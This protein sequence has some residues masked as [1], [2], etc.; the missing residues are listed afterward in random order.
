MFIMPQDL[1]LLILSLIAFS[2]MLIVGI[3]YCSAA[4]NPARRRA[5]DPFISRRDT[6]P[7]PEI[8][9]L[10]PTNRLTAE[11]CLAAL[12]GITVLGLGIA[13]QASEFKA[14]ALIKNEARSATGIITDL[15]NYHLNK[16][17]RYEI[18]FTFT[19]PQG[20]FSILEAQITSK[21]TFDSLHLGQ[22]IPI[23]YAASDPTLACFA[24]DCDLAKIDLL[25]IIVTLI[26]SALS[27]YYALVRLAHYR[28]ARQLESAGVRTSVL[29]L[30][31]PNPQPNAET[32]I[33]FNLPG[34]GTVRCDVGDRAGLN[35]GE[36]VHIFFLPE[37]PAIL[38]IEQAE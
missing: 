29:I 6:G 2:A 5:L 31:Q 1:I 15:Q 20:E 37:D 4:L 22:A 19:T 16:S 26:P 24:Q 38:R 23:L 36:Y 13:S 3:R 12:V 32:V 27:L 18:S 33:Q 21:S 25:D 7:T 11:F 8:H 10:L 17:T 9:P 30:D 35:P 14:A 28:Q 34:L